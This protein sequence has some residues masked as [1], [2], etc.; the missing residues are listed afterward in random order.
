M[1][2]TAFFLACAVTACA[3][4]PRRVLPAPATTTSVR[5]DTLLPTIRWTRA[6]AE[7][8][9][10][11][12]QIYGGATHAVEQ[13]SSGEPTG[14][15]G[16]IMDADETVLDNSLYEQERAR[17]GLG[18]SDASW[19]E[20][21]RR[22]AAP[23]LPGAA[24]FVEHVHALGGRVAIVTNR[25]D[26]LCGPTRVNLGKAGIGADVV[27]CQPAGGPGDK[28]PRFERILKGTASPEIP[29]LDVVMW[30]GDNIQDFPHLGQDIRL[31]PDSAFARF[32]GRF[33]VL[34][35][36]MYGSWERNPLP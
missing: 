36:P 22:E 21:V 30:V 23:A 12:L 8:R 3:T 28:N 10:L 34:P 26:S 17:A 2:L 14:R 18:Y 24:D 5:V 19:S 4:S 9:A 35:N 25:A 15:W 7:H 31:A 27:L 29:P 20:W 13:L 6:S 11:L 32:G 33:I 16:V 1:K